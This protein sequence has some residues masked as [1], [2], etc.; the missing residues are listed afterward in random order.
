[1][2]DS[3]GTVVLGSRLTTSGL[4]SRRSE[5][6]ELKLET[7]Q[8]HDTVRNAQSDLAKLAES[9]QQQERAAK[10]LE[11]EQRHVEGEL[12]DLRVRKRALSERREQLEK[13]RTL[14]ESELQDA[15]TRQSKTTDE[16]TTARQE[17]ALLEEAVVVSE[18]SIREIEDQIESADQQRERLALDTTAAKVEL[19]KSEQNVE[20][21]RAQA[22]QLQEDQQER[23]RALSESH[24]QLTLCLRKLAQTER[25]ILHAT[26]ELAELYLDAESLGREAKGL[27]ERRDLLATQRTQA[28]ERLQSVRQNIHQLEEKQHR[29]DLEAGEVRHRRSSLADRLRED[30]EIEIAELEHEPTAEEL[31]EREEVEREITDLRRKINNIGAVNLDA[32][33]E[34]DELES[35]FASLSNQHQDLTQAK[36]ALERIIHKINA[37]SRRL[38]QETLEAI[39][40]N[41][42]VLYRKAF[43]GGRADLALEEGVDVL[44]AGVDII[45]TPPGKPSFNNSLLSG[46]EKALT[47]VSLLLAIFQ[48]RPS[49]FCVLDEVDAPF[50]EANIG[51]FI[52]VLK[53]FLGWTKFVIVTHSKKTMTAASTL[54]GVTMQESGVSKRVS[55]QFED[56]SEDGH[57]R[58]EAVQRQ[59]AEAEQDERG[60][61]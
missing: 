24:G 44:E 46:G 26:S 32:L 6:R 15:E 55:V 28:G 1:M 39:R 20:G 41:F 19:A 60:A 52:E 45:A 21:L 34:L 18:Q 4:V 30:Y 16:M 29:R 37:D 10:Q 14:I 53:G 13:Q 42:Q 2:V 61:A 22:L 3:D 12:G 9:A 17:L 43:G 50:D 8:L 40:T 51:R 25:E 23:S 49:P 5:L 54:Y 47:A 11:A 33:G 56:V 27:V 36:E 7:N 58:E 57:I 59:D 48:Y 35:R 31:A 38:F